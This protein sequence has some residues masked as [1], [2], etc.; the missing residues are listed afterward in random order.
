LLQAEVTSPVGESWSFGVL[1]LSP[2]AFEEDERKREGEIAVMLEI[3]APLRRARRPH[4]L[5]GDFNA[6]AP[7]QRIDPDKVK[8]KTRNAW[9]ANGGQIPRRVIQRLLDEGY[10]DTLQVAKTSE[11]ETGGSFTTQEPGQRI[12][13]IFTF[14]LDRSR[15]KDAWIEHDRLAKYASD[16]FP[17]G[18]E[19]I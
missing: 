10:V 17:V 1:H 19:N 5:M 2:R 9:E 13:Y 15:I 14:G 18:A 11:A 8:K 4:V 6:N 3:F 16:H 12:D 7:Y